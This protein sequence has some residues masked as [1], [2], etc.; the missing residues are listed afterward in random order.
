MEALQQ[1]TVV[2]L[3]ELV[4]RYVISSDPT[5]MDKEEILNLLVRHSF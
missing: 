3:R 2:E 1:L 5:N 4:S